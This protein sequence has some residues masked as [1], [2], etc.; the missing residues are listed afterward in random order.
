MSKLVCSRHDHQERSVPM[1]NDRKPSANERALSTIEKITEQAGE[2]AVLLLNDLI[3]FLATRDSKRIEQINRKNKILKALDNTITEDCAKY[4]SAFS[5]NAKDTR[6]IIAILKVSDSFT[7]I[8]SLIKETGSKVLML[9]E[10]SH[11]NKLLSNLISL[12][13]HSELILQNSNKAFTKNDITIAYS[14]IK[15]INDAVDRYD[16]LFK[17]LLIA[18]VNEVRTITEHMYIQIVAKDFE[19]ITSHCR[20]ICEQVLFISNS[21][22]PE[23]K[24]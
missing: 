13:N 23:K 1:P 18:M 10:L 16:D 24:I 20:T 4:T 15:N 7:K 3:N 9:T 12:G 8:G 11:E 2:I 21:E 14:I 19:T 5:P 6:R 22:T 17:N